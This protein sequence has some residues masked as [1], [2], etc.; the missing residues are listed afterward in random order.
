MG[1]PAPSGDIRARGK[2]K[3]RGAGRDATAGISSGARCSSCDYVCDRIHS[4]EAAGA[5]AG[6][7]LEAGDDCGAGDAV[8]EARELAAGVTTRCCWASAVAW[9][10]ARLAAALSASLF[11]FSTRV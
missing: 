5:A 7:G 9:R 8:P 1:C 3:K 6:G 11:I 4:G 10:L 2:R